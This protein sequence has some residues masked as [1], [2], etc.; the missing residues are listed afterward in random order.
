MSFTLWVTSD[1][2]LKCKYCYE[3]EKNTIKM[4]KKIVDDAI[5]FGMKN[6]M[7]EN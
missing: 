7:K 4:N 3:G 1:C 6:F 5:S 2:N